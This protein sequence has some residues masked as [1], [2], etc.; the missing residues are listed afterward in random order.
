MARI[1]G[2]R[3]PRATQPRAKTRAKPK[4]PE[5]KQPKTTGWTPK[6]PA[7]GSEAAGGGRGG[8]VVTRMGGGGEIGD[9]GTYNPGPVNVPP[10]YSGGGE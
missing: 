5:P 8:G 7:G 1:T 4:K 2:T 10:R 6:A 9:R 3:T